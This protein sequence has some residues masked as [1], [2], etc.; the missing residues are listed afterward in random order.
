MELSH[1]L[2]ADSFKLAQQITTLFFCNTICCYPCSQETAS[3]PSPEP[4]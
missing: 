2:E 1:S 4:R 3:R